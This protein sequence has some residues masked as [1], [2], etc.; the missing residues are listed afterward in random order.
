MRPKT[1]HRQHSAWSYKPQP[2]LERL[3]TAENRNPLKICRLTYFLRK[4]TEDAMIFMHP[5]AAYSFLYTSQFRRM[6][7]L[8]NSRKCIPKTQWRKSWTT[9]L[10]DETGQEIV[11]GPTTNFSRQDKLPASLIQH[12]GSS[13]V[14]RSLPTF[15][16]EYWQLSHCSQDY[17]ESLGHPIS[18]PEFAPLHQ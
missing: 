2:E 8:D 6:Q 14:P 17:I 12:A 1:L 9:R 16:P 3:K 4:K 18:S 7:R 13:C 15:L 11:A 10:Q 5:R